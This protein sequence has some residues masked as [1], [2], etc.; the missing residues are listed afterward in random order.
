MFLLISYMLPPSINTTFRIIYKFSSPAPC[1][2][3][4]SASVAAPGWGRS[5]SERGNWKGRKVQRQQLS[6]PLSRL[7]GEQTCCTLGGG[8]GNGLF[9]YSI[10]LGCILPLLGDNTEWKLHESIQNVQEKYYT[11][12]DFFISSR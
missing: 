2:G 10:V 3:H 12:K 8:S 1:T 6:L 5:A 11:Q 9:K 7:P 4:M